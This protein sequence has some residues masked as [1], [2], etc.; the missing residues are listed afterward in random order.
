MFQ[1]GFAGT[2]CAIDVAASSEEP[3]WTTWAHVHPED[4]NRRQVF[5]LPEKGGQG[6]QC[7]KLV[8]EK[9]SDLFG[10]I[11]IYELGVE[12]FLS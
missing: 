4:V 7:M 11:T 12:G 2:Q 8:F 6:I 10:R 3:V 1:G 5:K 9:S